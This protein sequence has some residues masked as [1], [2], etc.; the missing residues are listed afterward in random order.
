MRESM[1]KR[2]GIVVAV[3]AVAI[4]VPIIVRG[5]TGTFTPDWTFKGSA[6]T[7]TQQIGQTSWKAEN[8]EIVATPPSPDGGWLLLNGGYQD[9]QVGGNFKCAGDCKVGVMLRSEKT[10]GGTNGLYATLAGGD[11]VAQAVTVD[12]Q[13]KIAK[14]DPLTR[15][16]AGQYRVAPAAPAA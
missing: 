16:A 5:Q 7:G 4:A 8:G 13:G 3:A 1:N 10:A 2:L 12:A 11:R 14:N 6:L 15:N 9:V